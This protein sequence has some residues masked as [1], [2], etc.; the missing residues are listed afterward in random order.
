[1]KK[2]LLFII[3]F[4]TFALNLY[5]MDY[6]AGTKEKLKK[7]GVY[8]GDQ[9]ENIIIGSGEMFLIVHNPTELAFTVMGQEA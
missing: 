7:M 9:S 4:T 5:A 6:D 1:M 3:Y 2:L 8:F